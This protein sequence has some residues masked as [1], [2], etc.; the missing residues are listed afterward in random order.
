LKKYFYFSENYKNLISLPEIPKNTIRLEFF[1]K[2]TIRLEFFGKNTI[3][4]EF[5]VTK[6]IF[7][8]KF[9]TN[10]IFP[11]IPNESYFSEKFQTNRIFSKNSK[12]I[13]FFLKISV[14]NRIFR[15]IFRNFPKVGSQL[16]KKIFFSGNF[17]KISVYDDSISLY[18]QVCV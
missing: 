1:G 11:K 2:N 12:R 17:P 7:S 5:S 18:L 13:V 15:K 6:R 16:K 8:E 10:R 14:T 9:Q 3:R 4:S